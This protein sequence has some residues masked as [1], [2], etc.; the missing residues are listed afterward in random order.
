MWIGSEMLTKHGNDIQSN[1]PY[2]YL[3]TIKLNHLV[4]LA[5]WQSVFLRNKCCGI[6]SR[7]SHLNFRYCSYFEQEVLDIQATTEC[8]FT[9]K[10]GC[11][12]VMTFSEVLPADTQ[13]QFTS[14]ISFVCPNGRVFFEEISGCGFD[15]HSSHLNFRNFSYLQQEVLDIQAI[16]ECRLTMKCVRDMIMTFS[17][18][19][20][21]DSQSQFSS[22]TRLVLQNG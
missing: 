16:T 12:M 1:A 18:I 9:M 22:L 21:T 19:V 10:C 5:K 11:D 20:N 17:E 14:I 7:T 13:S 4:G 6:D 15:S 3:L 2:S 8:S